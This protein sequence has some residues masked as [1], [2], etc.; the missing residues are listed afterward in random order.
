[1]PLAARLPSMLASLT[2]LLLVGRAAGRA[3]GERF[4]WMATALLASAPLYAALSAYVIFDMML[5]LCV[6]VVWL[7]VAREV[8]DR[9]DAAGAPSARE[10]LLRR[11]AMFAAI[12]AGILIKG[13]VMLA[14][15]LG[16]SLGAAL[17]LRSFK[18][19]AWLAWIPGWVL[20]LGIPGAWF[21][22][23]SARFPEYPHYAFVEE[24]FQRLTSNAFHRHQGWWFAPVVLV[25]GTL[26]W[27]LATP[28]S[29]ARWRAQPSSV[30]TA[31][32]AGLGFALFAAVFF[33]ISHSQLV[34]YLVPAI[35]PLAWCAAAMWERGGPTRTE[36]SGSGPIELSL[37]LTGIVLAALV[38]VVLA[39]VG[40][41]AYLTTLPTASHAPDTAGLYQLAYWL[42][43]LFLV[44]GIAAVLGFLRSS[45]GLLFAVTVAWVPAFVVLILQTGSQSTADSRWMVGTGLGSIS[46][47]YLARAIRLHGDRPVIYRR[48]YSPGTDFLLGRSSRL[49]SED[50]TEATSNYIVR[51]REVLR[52]R[53]LWTALDSLP[54]DTFAV[55]VGDPPPPGPGRFVELRGWHGRPT[56][57]FFPGRRPPWPYTNFYSDARFK[58]WRYAPPGD[59]ISYH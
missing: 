48:C 3:G 32:G 54:P 13:P 8:E 23:A 6:T 38:L 43:G 36:T 45:A 37:Q 55:V 29:A 35:P 15:A 34:T 18:P 11:L 5:A 1:T 39:P 10:I 2:L 51:Y 26:P 59:T 21:A 4:G 27:S 44:F 33:S 14:W 9:M 50:G 7:G 53:G 25:A 20:A 49:V 19:L 17:V 46:G 47:S 30:R 12:A 31:A 58:V 28:W 40:W 16:G 52:G 57:V 56:K 42:T 22:A 24:S 41:F